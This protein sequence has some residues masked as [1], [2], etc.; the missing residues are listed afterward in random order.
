MM[1]YVQIQGFFFYLPIILLKPGRYITGVRE[2]NN[3][4][5]YKRTYLEVIDKNSRNIT[6]F[7]FVWYKTLICHQ[8]KIYKLFKTEKTF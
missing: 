4:N 2:K 3:V 5:L 6:F 7:D 1:L 8:T